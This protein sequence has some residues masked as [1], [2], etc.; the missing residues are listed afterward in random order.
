MCVAWPL[1]RELW[2]CEP[3][4]RSCLVS[5]CGAAV[6]SGFLPGPLLFRSASLSSQPPHPWSLLAAQA[7]SKQLISITETSLNRCP[8]QLNKLL[9][10][11]GRQL[12]LQLKCKLG[13]RDESTA[14]SRCRSHGRAWIPANGC[15][16]RERFLTA[17]GSC[18]VRS[19]AACPGKKTG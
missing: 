5:A 2:V 3:P 6:V 9:C 18:S 13:H 1:P 16:S 19:P 4:Q 10:C 11:R 8:R 17:L 15:S 12:F 7:C 14:L